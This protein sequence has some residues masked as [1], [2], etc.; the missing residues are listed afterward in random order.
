LTYLVFVSESD[1]VLAESQIV[2]NTRK[3]LRENLP[4]SLDGNGNLRSRNLVTGEYALAVT[5]RWAVPVKLSDGRWSFKK[6]KQAD[7]DPIPVS[8]IL[9]SVAAAEVESVDEWLPQPTD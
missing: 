8:V 4:E 2:E 3:W 1:A 7:T 6:P 9:P 5:E